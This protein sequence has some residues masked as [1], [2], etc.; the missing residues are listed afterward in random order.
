MHVSYTIGVQYEIHPW[1]LDGEK[2]EFVGYIRSAQ[3]PEGFPVFK[4]KDFYK[5]QP[6][7]SDTKDCLMVLRNGRTVATGSSVSALMTDFQ[8]QFHYVGS[9]YKTIKV[10]DTEVTRDEFVAQARAAGVSDKRIQE[11][12]EGGGY[13]EEQNYHGQIKWCPTCKGI[14]QTSCC[15]C[16]CGECKTC[17]KRWVCMPP[18]D[19]NLI[20]VGTIPLLEKSGFALDFSPQLPHNDAFK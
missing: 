6:A 5:F 7:D 9:E 14:R 18:I 13:S 11:S 20:P 10:A 4:L 15:A 12:L 1:G 2:A 8:R 19:L 17:G 16:G 3:D